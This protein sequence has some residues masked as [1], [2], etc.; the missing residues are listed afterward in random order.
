MKRQDGNEKCAPLP[1]CSNAVV[2]AEMA[3]Y[4]RSG[5]NDRQG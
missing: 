5:F 1:A 4:K 3:G 2:N